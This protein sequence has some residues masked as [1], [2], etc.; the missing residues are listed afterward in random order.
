[1]LAQG[2]CS[3]AK[4]R[5]LAA[6]SSGLNFLKKKK[7]KQKIGCIKESP[8]VLVSMAAVTNYHKFNGLKQYKCILQL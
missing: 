7:Q 5:G 3:S 2:Q 4:R 8:V 6:V 1:M